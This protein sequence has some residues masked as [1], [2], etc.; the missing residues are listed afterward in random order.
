MISRK[1]YKVFIVIFFPFL[2]AFI[3]GNAMSMVLGLL[4]LW[5]SLFDGMLFPVWIKAGML[6][7]MANSLFL[8]GFFYVSIMII[9]RREEWLDIFYRFS[10]PLILTI[11]FGVFALVYSFSHRAEDG[12]LGILFYGMGIAVSLFLFLMLI[13]LV[14][15]ETIWLGVLVNRTKNYGWLKSQCFSFL[16][17]LF[18]PLVL[19]RL[20]NWLFVVIFLAKP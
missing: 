8:W 18:L 13:P 15:I 7:D 16:M 10:K 1:T 4:A 17:F 9:S 11:P 2:M 12:F 19:T 14:L 6:T 5:T 3:V 20:T